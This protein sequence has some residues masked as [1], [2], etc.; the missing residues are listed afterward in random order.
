M[1]DDRSQ[2]PLREASERLAV[3]E[4]RGRDPII[5][6][7]WLVAHL[8]PTLRRLISEDVELITTLS[9][10]HT[11]VLAEPAQLEHVI[12]DLALVA[13][14]AL[15]AGGTL[16]IETRGASDRTP[17][18]FVTVRV[19]ASTGG[20]G[21]PRTASQA[22]L[23]ASEHDGLA[24]IQ[25][26]LRRF[27]GRVLAES[28]P[29]LGRSFTI[30]LPSLDD[31]RQGVRPPVAQGRLGAS[32]TVLLVEDDEAVR[33]LVKRVLVGQGYAVIEARNGEEALEA[34][35][36]H[37]RRIDLLVTDAVMPKLGGDELVR[38]LRARI[39]Q[40]PVLVISGYAREVATE[41]TTARSEFLAKPFSPAALV[42]R[43][44]ALLGGHQLLAG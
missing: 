24:A 14:D 43:V 36:A 26:I 28:E 3:R 19:T 38:A 2:G 1:P 29:E 4:D 30:Q 23:E 5:D 32:G 15:P 31:S 37:P 13:R 9:G 20:T 12:L 6:L 21:G 34:E 33:A 17:S 25:E 42:S 10:D 39:P 40:L 8:A 41:S 18:G 27:G 11:R 22:Q 44:R 35:R 7:G 16:S